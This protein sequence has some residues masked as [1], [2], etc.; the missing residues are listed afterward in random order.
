MGSK[1]AMVILYKSLCVNQRKM[2]KELTGKEIKNTKS[3][4]GGFKPPRAMTQKVK[5]STSTEL[6]DS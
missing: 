2:I 1:L 4:K 3:I 6:A 5:N